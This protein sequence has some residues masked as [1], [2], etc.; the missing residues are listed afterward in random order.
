MGADRGVQIPIGLANAGVAGY[1][2]L[3]FSAPTDNAP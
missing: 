2:S 1:Q 3:K